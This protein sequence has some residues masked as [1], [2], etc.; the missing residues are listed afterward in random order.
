MDRQIASHGFGGNQMKRSIFHM[1]GISTVA[2]ASFLSIAGDDPPARAAVE[3]AIEVREVSGLA[4]YAYD[5]TGWKQLRPGKVLFAGAHV[6]TSAGSMVLL[7]MEEE[8]S[9]VR[10]G[11]S[12]RLELAKA[13]PATE[14]SPSI[15]PLQARTTS[16][17]KVRSLLVGR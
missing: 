11:P 3:H 8:G 7:A 2:L 4:E 12:R 17:A 15:A 13:A 6:R 9:F 10:V 1:V 16:P 14:I 5:S